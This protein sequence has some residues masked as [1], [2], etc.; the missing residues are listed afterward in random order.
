MTDE[1]VVRWWCHLI[2][3]GTR[4]RNYVWYQTIQK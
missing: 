3:V 4:A 2:Y 1:C